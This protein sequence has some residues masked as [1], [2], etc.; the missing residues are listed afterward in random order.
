MNKQHRILRNV[1]GSAPEHREIAMIT[2]NTPFQRR[3]LWV[4][5]TLLPCR[6][7]EM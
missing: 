6:R 5:F 2:G 7:D 4:F 3:W 1:S